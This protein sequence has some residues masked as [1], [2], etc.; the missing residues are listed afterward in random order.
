M[1][2]SKVLLA[3]NTDVLLAILGN[4]RGIFLHHLGLN[5]KEE[6]HQSGLNL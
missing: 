1:K 3:A 2:F 6:A 5:E 4:F